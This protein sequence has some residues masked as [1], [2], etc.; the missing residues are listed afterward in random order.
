M[1]NTH[2]PTPGVSRRGFLRGSGLAAAATALGQPLPAALADDPHAGH[3]PA[4]ETVAIGPGPV[5]LELNVNGS[6]MTT[7]VEAP[8]T[9]LDTLPKYL[10]LNRFQ[11]VYDR[12][13][14]SAYS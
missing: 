9:L 4:A 3:A 10:V 11:R 6:K 12:R 8:V 14:C 2:G 13:S 7:N 1:S 5:Q